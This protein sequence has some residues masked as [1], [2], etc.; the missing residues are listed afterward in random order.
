MKNLFILIAIAFI[1]CNENPPKSEAVFEED[2]CDWVIAEKDWDIPAHDTQCR[3]FFIIE[4]D[5]ERKKIFILDNLNQKYN[6][7]D[8]LCTK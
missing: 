3:Y 8:T 4:K 1:S 5:K 7:G 2:Y 6:T